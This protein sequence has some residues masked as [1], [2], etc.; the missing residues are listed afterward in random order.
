[1]NDSHSAA[2]LIKEIENVVAELTELNMIIF[3]ATEDVAE[4]L[5]KNPK[6][7]Y[8]VRDCPLYTSPSPRD[9]STSRMPSSACKKKY[10]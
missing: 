3:D 6:V 5:Y 4:Q 8:V 7:A 1:M 9:L 2:D 10:L